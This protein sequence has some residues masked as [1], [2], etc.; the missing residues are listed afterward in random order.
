MLFSR[1]KEKK[2][3]CYKSIAKKLPN[4]WSLNKSNILY[5]IKWNFPTDDIRLWF[6]NLYMTYLISRRQKMAKWQK[7]KFHGHLQKSENCASTWHQ[8]FTVAKRSVLNL[9]RK[10]NEGFFMPKQTRGLCYQLAKKDATLKA[11]FCYQRANWLRLAALGQGS[12][13]PF[14]GRGASNR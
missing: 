3:S 13:E 7:K 8:A 12:T 10:I 5:L 14:K 6:P 1:W 2:D 4:A 11:G 9:C